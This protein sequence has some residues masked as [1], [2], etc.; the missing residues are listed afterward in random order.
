LPLLFGG[1]RVLLNIRQA[2]A[3]SFEV[4]KPSN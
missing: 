2:S 3:T 4:C 1:P